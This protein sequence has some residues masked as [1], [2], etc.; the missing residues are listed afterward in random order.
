MA[1]IFRF[2]ACRCPGEFSIVSISSYVVYVNME[3]VNVYQ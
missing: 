2:G 1:F 3:K